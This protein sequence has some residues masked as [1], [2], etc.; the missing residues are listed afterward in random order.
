MIKVT[1]KGVQQAQE[2]VKRAIR[3]FQ[4]K[5]F[6]TIGIHEDT[7]IHPDSE[8]T[9]ATIGAV[10][11]FGDGKFIPPRLWLIPGVK[12]GEALYAAEVKAVADEPDGLE[13]ALERIGQIAAGKTKEYMINLKSPANAP[14]T[15]AAKKSAN[16][17]VGKE[18]ALIPSV[19]S[20]VVPSKPAE[21][22]I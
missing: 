6:V 21:G 20:K 22:G 4:T 15:I 9:N 13:L 18:G 14:S 8:L 11:N 12:S 16:P 17:L 3:D 10:L 1:T 19:N 2:A 7:G 5:A